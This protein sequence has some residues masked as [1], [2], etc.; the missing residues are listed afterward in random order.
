MIY[1]RCS[2]RDPEGKRFGNLPD[3]ATPAQRERTCPTLAKDPK[4]GRWGFYLSRG[5][6]ASGKRLQVR[7]ANFMTKREAQRAYAQ[8]KSAH[9]TGTFVQ[10]S[11]VKFA[12]YLRE[13]LGVK[14]KRDGI[15]LSTVSRYTRIIDKDLAP[16]RL[17]AMKVTDITR[18]DLKAFLDGLDRG[19]ET[20]KGIRQV[21][22][23]VLAAAV[24]DELIVVNPAERLPLPKAKR[25]H[26]EFWS[27]EQ[28]GHFLD[29]AAKHRLGNLFVVAMF[30]GLRRGEV[31]GLRWSDIDLTARTL[32]VRH[33]LVVVDGRVV[34][35]TPKTD[36][37]VRV[38][39]LDDSTV[40]ALLEWRLAQDVDRATAADAWNET[41]HVFTMEDG[42][43]LSPDYVYRLSRKVQVRAGVP[44]IA[45]H[46]L[47]H[48]HASL[49]LE[50]GVPI[51]VVSKRLG[52]A[53]I[54]ITSDLYSH[55]IGDASRDAASKASNL[56]P[57]NQSAQQVH[58]PG[59]SPGIKKAPAIPA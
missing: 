13:W 35:S 28:A 21:L 18:R 48:E 20:L 40:G 15:R 26:R 43:A 51:G 7:E 45:F 55:L 33:T 1:R 57:R 5:F 27:P 22:H 39:D 29:V 34:E 4:H 32:T 47:R 59:G 56:V 2:C 14:V 31:A 17:G 6:D 3:R 11:S 37:G 53:S 38:I 30:T 16:S 54:G 50:A 44:S 25:K 9:D 36:S 41:G 23:G 19:V 42:R 12:D 46:G 52:H 24:D 10:P 49:M 8:A 58:N